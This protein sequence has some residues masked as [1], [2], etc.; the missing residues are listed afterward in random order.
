MADIPSKTH[1]IAADMLRHKLK[2]IGFYPLQRTV[3]VHPYNPTKELN[4]LTEY[5]D[6]GKFVT[7]LEAKRIDAEDEKKLLNYFNL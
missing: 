3:W 4:E 1:R 6:L 5:Y 7:I 2:K